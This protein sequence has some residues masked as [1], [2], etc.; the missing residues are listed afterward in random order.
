MDWGYPQL[1]RELGTCSI[2]SFRM[3]CIS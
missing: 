1:Y 3:R 2:V